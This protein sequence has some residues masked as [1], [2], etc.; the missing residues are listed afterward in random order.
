MN[1][2]KIRVSA[3][4]GYKL[5]KYRNMFSNDNPDF[6]E[7]DNFKTVIDVCALSLC[8]IPCTNNA[9]F[10]HLL[11]GDMYAIIKEIDQIDI[12]EEYEGDYDSYNFNKGT[13]FIDPYCDIE[14]IHSKDDS[15]F[16]ARQDR[17]YNL[18]C[19]GLLVEI[20]S[21]YFRVIKY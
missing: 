3:F 18:C 13:D 11:N 7:S 15:D 5:N 8:S 4:E 9:I 14:I 6:L 10:I 12:Y 16:F 21:G 17:K 20:K 1:N 2:V 19:Y